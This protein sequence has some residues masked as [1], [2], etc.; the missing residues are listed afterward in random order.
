MKRK[1]KSRKQLQ[2]LIR[3]LQG[4]G[5]QIVFTNGCF[6]LLHIGHT[7]YLEKAKT[8]GDILVVAVNSDRSIRQIKDRRRPI[9]PENER[10]EVLAALNCVDYVT[11]FDEDTP[12]KLIHALR[13]NILVKGGDWSK[14]TIIGRETVEGDGGKV[15]TIPVVP[16]SSTSNIVRRI[17]KKYGRGTQSDSS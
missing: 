14:K 5:C 2:A 10:A 4:E 7:R 17:L 13:P 8:L 3:K 1:V 16:K 11:I 15:I 12:E 9:L 6:D